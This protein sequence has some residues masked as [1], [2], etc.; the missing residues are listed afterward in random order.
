MTVT[1]TRHHRRCRHRADPLDRHQPLGRFRGVGE[2]WYPLI[3]AGDPFI[4]RP[5]R[6]RSFGQGLPGQ[7]RQTLVQVGQHYRQFFLESFPTLGHY[8]AKF[9]P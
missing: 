3:I 9:T 7:H 5:Q 1:D 4:Q 6:G 8:Q 2:L